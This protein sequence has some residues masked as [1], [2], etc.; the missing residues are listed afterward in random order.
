MELWSKKWMIFFLMLDLH[1]HNLSDFLRES[2]ED[3]GEVIKEKIVLVSRSRFVTE[4]ILLGKVELL[5]LDPDGI[6]KIVTKKEEIDASSDDAEEVS[7]SRHGENNTASSD[8]RTGENG[9]EKVVE[10]IFSKKGPDATKAY[11]MTNG[12][13][14]K[15]P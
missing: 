10:K 6:V 15:K 13:S 9:K 12:E 7:D 1:L 8:D 11:N 14:N 4:Y 3:T 5:V 2:K